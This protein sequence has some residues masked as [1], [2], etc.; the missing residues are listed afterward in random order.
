MKPD[1]IK[2]FALEILDIEA[3]AI[4]NL[5]KHVGP[6]FLKA[7]QIISTCKGRV[8]LTG[9]GK[10]GFIARKIA[11]TMAS[12]GTPSF[13]VH[14]AEAVHGDLGMITVEDAVIAISQSGESV[15]VVSFLPVLKKFGVPL[16]EG[17]SRREATTE[18]HS[19]WLDRR[20]NFAGG[21]GFCPVS[22]FSQSGGTAPYHQQSWPL[23]H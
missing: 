21:P 9:M 8:I 4:R 16:I 2:K 3:A 5:R 1:Q 13:F 15:D 19:G 11:A 7:V 6:S 12:T 20:R 18:T 14:P 22:E 10:P 23:G 17:T